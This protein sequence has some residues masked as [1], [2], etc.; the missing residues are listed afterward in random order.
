MNLSTQQKGPYFVPPVKYGRHIGIMSPSTL[1]S[2][3]LSHIWFPINNSCRNASIP[4]KLH[5]RVNHHKIQAKLEKWGNLHNFD[6]VMAFLA[7]LSRRLMG[8]LIVYQ[9]LRPTSSV[10]RLLFMPNLKQL[11][12]WNHWANLIQIS[13]GDS[14]GCRNECLFKWSWSHD[15]DGPYMVKT[16]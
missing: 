6:W 15:E 10:C 9:S 1:L 4:F 7:H 14:L 12:L 2:S 16:L 13:Y 5:R 11:L 3:T 8:E